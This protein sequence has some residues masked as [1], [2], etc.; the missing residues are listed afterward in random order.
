MQPICFYVQ[1]SILVKY[2]GKSIK[3]YYSYFTLYI[4]IYKYACHTY[5]RV[6][7]YNSTTFNYILESFLT[8]NVKVSCLEML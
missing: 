6:E 2:V 3:Q 5:N 4:Y 8:I 1:P 7:K